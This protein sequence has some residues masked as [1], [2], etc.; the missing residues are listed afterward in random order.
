MAVLCNIPSTS[1]KKSSDPR[2]KQILHCFPFINS[3]FLSLLF[4]KRR[5]EPSRQRQS[6]ED[7]EDNDDED[8]DVDVDDGDGGD[9]EVGQMSPGL[10]C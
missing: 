9:D 3:Q 2:Y 1:T 8:V 6:I 10:G 4:T 5:K 7:L